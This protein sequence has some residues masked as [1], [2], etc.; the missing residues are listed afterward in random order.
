MNRRMTWTI[1]I[2]VVLVIGGL[3]WWRWFKTY[4]LATVDAGKLY[5]DGNRNE[6]VFTAALR[7]K[8][9]KTVVC[10]ADDREIAQPPFTDELGYCQANGSEG[11][12]RPTRLG[13]WPT[14]D[15]VRKFWSVAT[16]PKKQPVLVH[17]AQGVRR[18]GIMV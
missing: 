1:G 4:P 3:V 12:R 11:V 14:T 18:T 15:Q 10:L 13:A 7:Q 16:D 2:I 6:R 5:R 17:C 8:K 9:V